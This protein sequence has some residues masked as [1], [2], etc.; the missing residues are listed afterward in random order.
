MVERVYLDTNV[1]CRPFDDQS[2][3]RIRTESWAF[4]EIA[5][6]A[7]HGKMV[8]VSSDYVKFEIERIADS[9][10]RK[11]VRG[12]ERTLAPVNVVSSKQI[13]SLARKF[14]AKCGLNPMDAL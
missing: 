1:Y 9:L 14:S 5:D 13:I 7:S 4:I 10:K 8:I 11:D 6:A 2:D 12:F 3:K